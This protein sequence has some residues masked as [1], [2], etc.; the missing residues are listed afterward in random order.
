VITPQGENDVTTDNLRIAQFLFLL[1]DNEEIRN[2]LDIVTSKVVL[3]L[4]RFT[5]ERKAVLDALRTALRRQYWVPV[6]LD[7]E[8]PSNRNL[9]ETISTLAHLARFVIADLADA[10]SI[11]QELQRIVPDLPSLPVQP[12]ILVSQYE[13]GMF[14]DFRDYP[15]VLAPY[16]YGS[17]EELLGSLHD[18]VV[19]PASIKAAEIAERRRLFRDGA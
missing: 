13:Y 9:T 11:P 3:I 5:P 12:I 4:G 14:R 7:F 1:L 8:R 2:V 16:R 18:R 6:V 19:G 15:W 17:T 10:K